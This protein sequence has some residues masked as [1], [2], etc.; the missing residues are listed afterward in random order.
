MDNRVTINVGLRNIVYSEKGQDAY[1]P[2]ANAIADA[3]GDACHVGAPDGQPIALLYKPIKG[4]DVLL[5]PQSVMDY[6]QAFDA[7]QPVH[8]TSFTALAV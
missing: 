2:I 5:L 3:T 1:C 7:G 8:P 6:W 4:K